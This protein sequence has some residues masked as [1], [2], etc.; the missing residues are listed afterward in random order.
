MRIG[1]SKLTRA[2]RGRWRRASIKTTTTTSKNAAELVVRPIGRFED[3]CVA[4]ASYQ[5]FLKFFVLC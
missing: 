4:G 1:D 2:A 5:V 3:L